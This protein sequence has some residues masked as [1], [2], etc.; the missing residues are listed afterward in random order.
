VYELGREYG[1]QMHIM[2]RFKNRGK[3]LFK[4]QR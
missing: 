4:P 3:A 1:T 2:Y